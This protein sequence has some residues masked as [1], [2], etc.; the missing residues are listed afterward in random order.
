IMYRFNS[1]GFNTTQTL[2]IPLLKLFFAFSTYLMLQIEEAKAQQEESVSGIKA[3]ISVFPLQQLHVHGSSIVELPS[4]NLLSCWFQG[5]GERLSNDVRI[6]GSLLKKGTLTWS[7]PFEMAD[8]PGLPDCN[9]VLFMNAE[10]KLFLVWIA[11]L[12]NRWEQSLLRVKTSTQFNEQG[13][14]LWSWQD[15]ILLNPD[16]SFALSVEKGFT[17]L[18]QSHAGWSEFAPA[19]D[20][21]IIQAA[22]EPQKRAIGWMTRIKP[23]LSKTGSIVLP[24]YSDGF[25]FSIMAISRD[26]GKS[27][28]SSAPIVSRG[29][30]QP[31]LLQRKNG[32]I[33][34]MMRDNG[35]EPGSIKTSI[36]KDDG[37]TW[38]P[39]IKT[40]IPNP[41]SSVETL[42]L[43]DGTIVLICND[44]ETGRHKLSMYL[45]KDDGTTWKFVGIID[46]DPNQKDGF[47]YPAAIQAADGTIHITY[48]KHTASGKT[49][50]HAAIHPT[51]ISTS[52]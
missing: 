40:N 10:G 11:V 38:S 4:G 15:N 17:Q 12:A 29:G 1:K 30:I 14:P 9:P 25:N 26:Q 8:T 16:E 13:V 27:W 52:K 42:Q 3:N 22:R 50:Q 34:A 5:S 35:D 46:K 43:R 7:T 49:I 20:K 48:S 19:Y 37:M 32:D 51:V 33:V 44:L 47:S 45:S 39:A 41:G 23:L 18:E 31:A 36:S 6:M 28:T 24:L 2:G 21:M